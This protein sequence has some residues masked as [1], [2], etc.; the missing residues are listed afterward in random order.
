MIGSKIGNVSKIKIV[1]LNFILFLLMRTL[2]TFS[3]LVE[4]KIRMKIIRFCNTKV[5]MTPSLIIWLLCKKVWL[6]E[7]VNNIFDVIYQEARW[8][9]RIKYFLT[10]WLAKSVTEP[11]L[12][13]LIFFP[14][15]LFSCHSPNIW[16]HY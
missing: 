4:N 1:S 5:Q 6:G 3:S 7:K 15:S 9:D 14:F 10:R 16:G 12:S 13:N 11:N 2:F 8:N